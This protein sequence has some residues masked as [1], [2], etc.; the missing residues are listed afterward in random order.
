MAGKKGSSRGRGKGKDSQNAVPDIYQ[1]MLAEALPDQPEIPERPLKRRRTGKREDVASGKTHD[2]DEDEDEDMQFEDVLGN[3]EGSE[4]GSMLAKRQQTA[5][6]DSDEESD[7]SDFNLDNFDFDT[8]PAADA[9]SGDLELTLVKKPVPQAITPRRKAVTKADKEDRLLKHKMHV[10]CLV[11]AL[12]RANDW[13][14]DAEVQGSLKPLLTMKMLTFL[15]PKS[16]LSQF[17][18]ADS[19]KRGLDDVAILWRTKFEITA[20]GFRRALWADDDKDLQNV[21]YEPLYMTKLR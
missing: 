20:R 15:R 7:D 1:E 14:N 19:V 9:P 2:S 11:S 6:R 13:C 18:R 8:V 4:N 16:S 5:Y 10:L 21:S 17:G 3:G 12:D